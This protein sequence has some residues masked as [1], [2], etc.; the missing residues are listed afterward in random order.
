MTKVKELQYPDE[1]ANCKLHACSI[2]GHRQKRADAIDKYYKQFE[3]IAHI[4]V[5]RTLIRKIN[6]E[7]KNMKDVTVKELLV[8]IRFNLS[9]EIR[10]LTGFCKLCK[11]PIDADITKYPTEFDNDLCPD[12]NV[13]YVA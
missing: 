7:L 11:K 6:D 9:Q 12:C 1:C 5:K 13:D 10:E 2:C 4:R 8:N 3:R